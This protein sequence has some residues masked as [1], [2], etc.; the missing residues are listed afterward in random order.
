[1][2]AMFQSWRLRL[3]EVEESLRI[4]RLDEASTMLRDGGLLEY[5]PA[6]RLAEKAALLFAERAKRRAAA[7][8]L[9]G[10]WADLEAALSLS[11]LPACDVAR[12]CLIDASLTDTDVLVRNGELAGAASQLDQLE[13][14]APTHPRV[15]SLRQ[16]VRSLQ[17]ARNLCRH[18]KFADA[19]AQFDVAIAL[20]PDLTELVQQRDDC[21]AKLNRC[22]DLSEQ[23]YKAMTDS[24]WQDTLAMA[25]ELLVIAP[26]L[27]LARVARK[28]AWQKA[29]ADIDVYGNGSTHVLGAPSRKTP[30]DEE[31]ADDKPGT[32]FLLWVDGV[33]GYLVCLADS[34]LLGQ[35]VPGSSIDVPILGDLSRRHAR[36]SRSGEGYVIEPMHAI[37]I[38]GR[39]IKNPMTLS[40]QDEIELGSG[41]KYRFRRP[42][43]LSATARLDPISRHRIQPYVDG[44]LLMAESCVLGPKWQ[45]HI[46]CRDWTADVVLYRHDDELFCRSIAPVE[47]DG[48]LCEGRGRL[49][50]N[51][52]VVGSDFSMCLEELDR[53]SSQPLR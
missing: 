14:H 12:R 29:G 27:K 3:R 47:I 51:S 6:K 41:V 46:V 31:L 42:H 44:V 45:N 48:K 20:R 33:G 39:A 28:R 38:N 30:N 24:N 26:E 34:V 32:R 43:A 19:E 2:V 18:G 5:L 25:D 9:Q 10:G 50:A 37:S 7:R 8:D 53:C 17:S 36:V 13:K 52:R 15:N 40:D 11:D 35:H 1:V 21:H 49:E 4:G 23:L 22:R 16:V